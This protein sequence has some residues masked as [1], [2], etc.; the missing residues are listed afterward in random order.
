MTKH[1]MCNSKEYN[2]WQRMKRCCLNPNEASY[3]RYGAR[4]V[5]ICSEWKGDFSQFLKDMGEMPES[6][7]GLLLIDSAKEFCKLNCKW[8]KKNNGRPCEDKKKSKS[9]NTKARLKNPKAV[10]INLEQDHLDFIKAQALK[11]SQIEGRIIHS[12]VLMREALERQFP[13]PK[14]F[15][16]FGARK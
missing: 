14:Q 11:Q 2:A 4:G 16:M 15:D 6:C 12:Q 1:K 7:N 5:T 3:N 9:L 8:Y 10:C 13:H